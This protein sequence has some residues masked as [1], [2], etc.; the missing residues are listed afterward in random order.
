MLKKQGM[1]M[2]LSPTFLDQVYE[3]SD[4]IT[5]LRNL[6]AMGTYKASRTS[7]VQLVAKMIGK[8]YAD[9]NQR[10]VNEEAEQPQKRPCCPSRMPAARGRSIP[11]RST[12]TAG[13]FSGCPACWVRA[14]LR[15]CA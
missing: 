3:V 5:V 2:V 6:A 8:E 13:R 11:F 15:L 14:A 7:R 10:F 4:T 12:S 9:L 1:G